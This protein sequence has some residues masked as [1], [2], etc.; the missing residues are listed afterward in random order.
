MRKIGI[1]GGSFNP[2]HIAHLVLAERAREALGLD[3]VLFVPA[4]LPPHKDPAGLAGAEQ[5]LE[6]VRLAI[7]G[8]PAF[9]LSDVELRRAGISFT[10]DTIEALRRRYSRAEL[11]FLIGMDTVSELPTWREI[12]RLAR[13]CRFVPLSRPG[14]P[15][16]STRALA[17]RI[18]AAEARAIVARAVAMPLL[19]ISASDI[20]ARIARGRTVRYLLPAAVESYI[21][22]HRLYRGP[23]AESTRPAK[24]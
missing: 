8:N 21:R 19:D 6:M 4:R 16:A 11:Y 17:K 7:A 10:I 9:A 13:L 23:G 20:R 14:A 2:V 22:T 15:P 3:R 24:G 12:G 1:L 5:R 18:G